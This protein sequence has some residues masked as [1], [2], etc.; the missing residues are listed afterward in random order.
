MCRQYYFTL[1]TTTW[2]MGRVTIGS[3]FTT[4]GS[5]R[6]VRSSLMYVGAQGSLLL[7]ASCFHS[8][9]S[10]LLGCDSISLQSS[11]RTRSK[12]HTISTICIF[13]ERLFGKCSDY[14]M[15]FLIFLFI[16]QF[17]IFLFHI[18]SVVK[19]GPSSRRWC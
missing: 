15:W 18:V 4:K 12:Y 14:V 3:F 11:F 6:T 1:Q 13:W 10:R 17:F 19:Q 8:S 16:L 7:S 2:I 9:L 5:G